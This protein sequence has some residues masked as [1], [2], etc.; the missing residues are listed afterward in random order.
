MSRAG[1]FDMTDDLTIMPS[2]Y[3]FWQI[4]FGHLLTIGSVLISL[5]MMY[6]QV[7]GKL[8]GLSEKVAILESDYSHVSAQQNAMAIAQSAADQ[9]RVDLHKTIE[10]DFSRRLTKLEDRVDA[11]TK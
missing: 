5:G 10:D 2:P 7:A 9:D 4:N 11:G 3:R 6:A 1:R 8:E